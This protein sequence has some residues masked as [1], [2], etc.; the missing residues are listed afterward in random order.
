MIG[1]TDLVTGGAGF[2]G[3]ELVR[4][5]SSAGRRVV[6]L[7]NLETGRAENL[8]G[9]DAE[10]I[11]GSILDR[12]TV[13]DCVADAERVFHL[14]CLGLRRSIHDPTPV[15]EV[16]ATGALVL[17]EA[18][19]RAKIS[20][21]VHVSSSEVYG[22]AQCAPM[23]ET[24][25]TLPTTPYGASKLAGEAYARAAFL[26]YGLP[27]A[28]VR[29]FNSFGPRAHHEGDCGE[30]IPRFL[31]RALAGKPLVVFGDGRQTRDFTHVSDTVRGILLA[32]E[33]DA[34]IGET[35][36]LGSGA[37]VAI[38]DLAAEILAVTKSSSPILHEPPRPGDVR[39]HCADSRRAREKLGWTP[40]TPL[41]AGL[42]GLY[43]DFV[44][45]GKRADELLADEILH[46]WLAGA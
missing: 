43:R 20:R 37:E 31:L 32:G 40:L 27:V 45:S 9:V 5:L 23:D 24:H 19:R 10:L 2:I 7:D 6:V 39:R 14:A 30:V 46:N 26:T 22:T 41:A 12:E 36:N 16:N 21:F 3:S 38:N 35:I 11:V 8:A 44:Q 4:Q 34:A 29:P 17:L 42:C 25:P 28:I 33:T 15:H 13:T 1:G 18:A